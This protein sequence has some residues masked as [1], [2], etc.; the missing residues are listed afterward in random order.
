MSNYYSNVP[1]YNRRHHSSNRWSCTN[2]GC[3]ENN[4]S[5]EYT[6]LDNCINSCPNN[7]VVSPYIYQPPVIPYQPYQP[8]QPYYAPYQP[9]YMSYPQYVDS[10][11]ENIFVQEQPI[12]GYPAYRPTCPFYTGYYPQSLLFRC[13][14]D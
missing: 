4:Y 10:R 9:M 5:G 8:F 13:S 7:R 2:A 3:I 11:A 1:N 12:L 14:K 6:N